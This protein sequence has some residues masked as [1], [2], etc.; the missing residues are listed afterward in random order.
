M[1]RERAVGHCG[2]ARQLLQ[3][4]AERIADPETRE[5]VLAADARCGRAVEALQ[6]DGTPWWVALQRLTRRWGVLPLALVLTTAG[7]LA[8]QGAQRAR[9]TAPDY[10]L[11]LTST[12]LIVADWSTTLD[13]S[14]RGGHE[15]NPLLGMRPSEGRVNT[16]C[17]LAVVG[18]LAASRLPKWPR[19]VIWL[20]VAA[21]EW[22]AVTS[23]RHLGFRFVLP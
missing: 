10:V 3:A 13:I 12:A 17:A 14:R 19:R 15:M 18:N 21:V 7:T 11:G 9:L 2:N 6:R 5:L 20:A 16:M 4:A 23:N 8:G 1:Q 22:N